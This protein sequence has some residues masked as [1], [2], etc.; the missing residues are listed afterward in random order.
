MA[1]VLRIRAD[2]TVGLEAASG[3]PEQVREGRWLLLPSHERLLIGLGHE[4]RAPIGG[5]VILTGDLGAI[6]FPDVITLIG[7]A[8]LTGT[9]RVFGRHGERALV[10]LDGEVRGATSSRPGDRL[11]QIMVHD[12]MISA[13][14][15]GPILSEPSA[16]RRLGRALVERGHITANQ[17]WAAIRKQVSLVFQGI[18]LET[19]AA[20]VLSQGGEQPL[21]TPGLQGQSLLLDGLRQLDELGLLREPIPPDAIVRAAAVPEVSITGDQRELLRR[22]ERGP[23]TPAKL[24]EEL[25]L[26][27]V[28]VLRALRQLSQAG[29][30][31]IANEER[32]A[33]FGQVRAPE[34]LPPIVRVFNQIFREVTSEAARHGSAEVAREV[35]LS[36]LS[37][38]ARR[39]LFLGL[40]PDGDGVLDEAQLLSR[41]MPIAAE[42][43]AQP[44]EF[45]LDALQQVMFALLFG[46]GEHL[47][48]EANEQLTRKVKLLFG[49]LEE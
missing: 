41:L 20:F 48:A 42:A 25:G 9:L 22:L 21:I 26:S 37:D 35:F 12:G 43:T 14:Q 11:G 49:M 45:L 4:T 40:A 28:D 46:V 2:G 44:Q 27:P 24:S 16:G 33:G 36:A 32:P 13:E 17:L 7:Q 5:R 1:Q 18:L 29:F 30:V 10:F 39:G 3:A 23:V 38:P 15:L 8:R 6:S 31:S 19:T 34:A 47:T